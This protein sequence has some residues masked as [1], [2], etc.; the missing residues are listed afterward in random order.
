MKV[1]TRFLVLGVAL[2]ATLSRPAQAA[3]YPLNT[4]TSTGNPFGGCAVK[5]YHTGFDGSGAANTPVYAAI[6]GTVK[7]KGY[8]NG[9]GGMLII[10][11]RVGGETVCILEAHMR[12]S[13]IT[14][15]VGA[16]VT[17]GQQIGVLGYSNENG[18]WPEHS[19]YAVHRGPYVT[20]NACDETWKFHGYTTGC[21]LGSWYDPMKF[22][23]FANAHAA[24]GGESKLGQPSSDFITSCGTLYREYNGGS[25]G[26]CALVQN[27]S[28]VFLVRTGFFNKYASMGGV[29]SRL[30]KPTGNE[31]SYYDAQ[32]YAVVSRQNFTGG[33]M[34]WWM[35][36]AYVYDAW[37]GR[38]ASLSPAEDVGPTSSIEA[39]PWKLVCTPNP[40]SSAI[41]LQFS[42]PEPG[43]VQLDVF[44]VGGRHVA[45][46][47]NET[48]QPGAVNVRWS[49]R[50]AAGSRVSN[51]VYFARLRVLGHEST[52]RFTISE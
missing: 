42:M 2:C 48:H 17:E 3:R 9:Y 18:G 37:G 47:M 1:S 30:G 34:I 32:R 35:N 12:S 38:I 52:M 25:Y 26:R 10:E 21:D 13:S 31:Y 36:Y 43:H 40:A 49:L 51:G 29:C 27:G 33:Y 7:L 41:A 16:W 50:D 6:S 19:H 23:P 8:V 14:V 22:N 24:N 4:W 15:A 46:L 28:N 39:A 44:D 5:C 20:G 11:G 45:Q